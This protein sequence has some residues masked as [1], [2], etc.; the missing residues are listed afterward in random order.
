MKKKEHSHSS[1][2]IFGVVILAL[3]LIGGLFVIST[4]R[5]TG[6]TWFWQNWR[7][8]TPSRSWFARFT[9]E[10]TATGVVVRDRAGTEYFHESNSCTRVEVTT[11]NQISTRLNKYYCATSYATFSYTARNMLA[12]TTVECPQGCDHG[13]CIGAEGSIISQGSTGK[14]KVEYAA[15]SIATK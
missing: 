11:A 3:L 10:P 5:V 6:N 9:C 15:P 12:Y 14:A 4:P 8:S 7:A 1:I 2:L 13:P